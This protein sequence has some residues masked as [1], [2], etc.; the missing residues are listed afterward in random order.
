MNTAATRKEAQYPKKRGGQTQIPT[1]RQGVNHSSYNGSVKRRQRQSLVLSLSLLLQ[2]MSTT[3]L[4]AHRST[5][6]SWGND[7][8][9]HRRHN[10]AHVGSEHW[11][12]QGTG[13]RASVLMEDGSELSVDPRTGRVL[14][15][16]SN[17]LELL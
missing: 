11:R 8:L 2:V 17:G 9:Q 14:T 10:G 16:G 6:Q 13:D 4:T 3:W 12:G 15:D 1:W 7:D 5:L